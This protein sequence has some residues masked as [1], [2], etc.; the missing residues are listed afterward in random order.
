[1]AAPYDVAPAHAPAPVADLAVVSPQFCAPYTVPLTVTKKV[2]SISDSN[3]TVTDSNGAVVMQVKGA[4][5]SIR[6]RRVLHDAAGQP[7]ITMQEEH[8]QVLS[9]HNR[10]EVF[11]GDSTEARYLLF[12]AKRSSVMQLKTDMDVFLAGNTTQQVCDF[13]MKG[14]YFERSCAF[15]LGNSDIMIARMDRKYTVSNVMLGKDTPQAGPELLTTTTMPSRPSAVVMSQV[16]LVNI[17][18]GE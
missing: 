2:M 17:A 12:T 3:F 14:S 18:I 10:W 6:N 7:A 5:L 11:R 4:I 13:K 9:M 1:M 15:Y 16:A 8:Y